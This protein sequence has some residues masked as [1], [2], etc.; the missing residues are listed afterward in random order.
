MH[1]NGY[2]HI[3]KTVHIHN[4]RQY[5]CMKSSFPNHDKH[6]SKEKKSSLQWQ[7]HAQRSCFGQELFIHMYIYTHIYICA[8]LFSK[9]A[10]MNLALTLP[11]LYLRY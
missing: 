3:T 10:S 11:T 1:I 7:C 2:I 4:I 8:K 5:K 9:P 6:R